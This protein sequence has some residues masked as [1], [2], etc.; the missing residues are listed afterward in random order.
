MLISTRV[1]TFR[2]ST[3]KSRRAT[4]CEADHRT[5][6]WAEA[7]GLAF[8]ESGQGF[9]HD[10]RANK[11]QIGGQVLAL[12]PA[13]ELRLRS[14][15]RD[16]PNVRTG[17][18]SN[19]GA[20]RTPMPIPAARIEMKRIREGPSFRSCTKSLSPLRARLRGEDSGPAHRA[21][22]KNIVVGCAR[23]S[24]RLATSTT[25]DSCRFQGND[26]GASVRSRSILGMPRTTTCYDRRR[27]ARCR[28]SSL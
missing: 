11:I 13:P 6:V 7:V 1:V 3:G 9:V 12:I 2:M 15:F 26:F 17:R 22:E 20:S 10:R 23:R 19:K 25:K 16:A 27:T 5:G 14:R 4:R 21:A 8:G 28:P 24:V 18:I